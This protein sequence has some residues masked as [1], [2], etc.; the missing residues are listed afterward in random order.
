MVRP[1][2]PWVLPRPP[3][4]FRACRSLRTAALNRGADLDLSA[5]GSRAVVEDTRPVP[6]EGGMPSSQA[7]GDAGRASLQGTLSSWQAKLRE[8]EPLKG[9]TKG[10][11]SKLSLQGP[12]NPSSRGEKGHV[13]QGRQWLLTGLRAEAPSTYWLVLLWARM[14][15]LQ[16][17]K[18]NLSIPTASHASHRPGPPLAFQ[19]PPPPRE[20]STHLCRARL[21]QQIFS[22]A[23]CLKLPGTSLL[24]HRL[25]C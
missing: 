4:D 20:D 11:G 21:R 18:V 12:N 14:Q 5:S 22:P 3:G 24:G 8:E 7:P 6:S 19:A 25:R 13:R 15:V 16:V 23:Q 10:S 2:N 1:G 9:H 17:W